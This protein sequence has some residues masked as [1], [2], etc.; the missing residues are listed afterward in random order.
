VRRLALVQLAVGLPALLLVVFG[1]VLGYRLAGRPLGGVAF[2]CVLAPVVGA[3]ALYFIRA[4][5]R[6]RRATGV[7]AEASGTANEE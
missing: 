6:L 2:W 1:V 4:I 3:F 5:L 7:G